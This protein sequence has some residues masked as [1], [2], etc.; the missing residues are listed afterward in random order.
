MCLCD[1]VLKPKSD[2]E[3]ERLIGVELLPSCD[4]RLSTALPSTSIYFGISEVVKIA[5]ENAAR[6]AAEDSLCQPGEGSQKAVGPVKDGNTAR[7]DSALQRQEAA[8]KIEPREKSHV[9]L[10]SQKTPSARSDVSFLKQTLS[11]SKKHGSSVQDAG[12]LSVTDKLVKENLVVAAAASREQQRT[13]T[14]S[15]EHGSKRAVA[16][17]H[18]P[19]KRKR[20]DVD[21]L[22]DRKDRFPSMACLWDDEM[23]FLQHLSQLSYFA[24][25]DKNPDDPMLLMSLCEFD[26]IASF[27]RQDFISDL[28]SAFIGKKPRYTSVRFPYS[29]RTFRRLGPLSLQTYC[30]GHFIECVPV[31]RVHMASLHQWASREALEK[32]VCNTWNDS[33]PVA[34]RLP[35]PSVRC[36]SDVVCFWLSCELYYSMSAAGIECLDPPDIFI[37]S[38]AQS[39]LTTNCLYQMFC[40]YV[41]FLCEKSEKYFRDM[42]VSYTHLTLPT[43]RIV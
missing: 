4:P 38:S 27:Q 9:K 40:R 8:A 31:S 17:M 36:M 18:T 5:I 3:L 34:V 25:L 42:A 30:D 23:T 19:R 22:T 11:V 14:E 13:D 41:D 7:N 33:H 2:A 12:S 6:L 20:K 10:S 1:T 37:G 39:E 16:K 28:N 26:D 29:D 32:V 15:V 21:E 24:E 43:K 35:Y